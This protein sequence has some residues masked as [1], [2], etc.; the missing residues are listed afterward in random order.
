MNLALVGGA[1]VAA[2]ALGLVQSGAI[3]H[4]AWRLADESRRRRA[5]RRRGYV[6]TRRAS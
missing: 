1:S 2:I 6:D 5:G 3:D 4:L